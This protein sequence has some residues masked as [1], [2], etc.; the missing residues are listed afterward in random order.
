[1]KKLILS[2]LLFLFTLHI[3]AQTTDSLTLNEVT[4]NAYLDKQPLLRTP[5]SATLLDSA[6][7]NTY[8]GHSR[9]F[10]AFAFRDPECEN[11]HG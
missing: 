1:M 6:A 11:L 10:V 4:I 9:K 2:F 3:H 5:A 7:L 8:P